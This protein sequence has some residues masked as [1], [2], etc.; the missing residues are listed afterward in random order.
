METS[1]GL[2]GDLG[3]G[4][5]S[6]T[7]GIALGLGVPD[8]DGVTS[9]TFTLCN[10][11]SG[12]IPFFHLD[13]YRLE[14]DDFFETGLDEYFLR[15]GVTVLEW[16]EKIAADL[17][18]PRLEVRLDFMPCGGRRAVLRGVGSGYDETIDRIRRDW[19]DRG[20]RTELNTVPGP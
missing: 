15:P 10:E 17:P 1:W 19:S 18:R 13:L 2:I 14:G 5:T 9:P 7:R 6:L 12:R 16:A 4:K 8:D 11:Y 20:L 3:V